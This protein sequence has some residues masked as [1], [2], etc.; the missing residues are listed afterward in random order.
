MNE[1]QKTS[2]KRVDTFLEVNKTGMCLNHEI[3]VHVTVSVLKFEIVY[4]SK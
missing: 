2:I 3:V 4:G 1:P